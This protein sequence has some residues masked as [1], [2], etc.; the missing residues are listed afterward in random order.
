MLSLKRL[1]KSPASRVML[2]GEA[3]VCRIPLRE[4]CGLPVNPLVETI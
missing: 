4:T 1:R 2:S 3:S